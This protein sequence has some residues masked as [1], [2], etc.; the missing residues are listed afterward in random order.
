MLDGRGDAFEVL[1][2]PQAYEKIE[3]LTKRN[4]KRT[5]AAPYGC[6]QRTFDAN[7][8]FAES[9]DS[10]VRQ[11]F[12]KFV[13]C[14]LAC[15]YLKPRDLLLA[16]EGFLDRCIEHARTRCPNVWPGAVSANERNDRLIRHI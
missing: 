15:E 7:Q 13:F 16:V 4:V 2:R 12:I 6:G 8:K 14:R 5:N 10:V 11:P 3:K 1:H 9:F